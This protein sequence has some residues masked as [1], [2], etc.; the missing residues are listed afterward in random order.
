MTDFAAAL[1]LSGVEAA[2]MQRTITPEY[3]CQ[4]CD[5]SRSLMVRR[6]SPT[7]SSS[8][9]T[10]PNALTE[11][12][13]VGSKNISKMVGPCS[14]TSGSARQLLFIQF[15]YHEGSGFRFDCQSSRRRPT[16]SGREYFITAEVV[17]GTAVS[18][19]GNGKSPNCW[20]RRHDCGRH[21]WARP[22]H[23]QFVVP[24]TK[25]AWRDHR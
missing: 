17:D 16:I 25:P 3:I 4:G 13:Q 18:P 8:A 24:L 9:S 15:S 22:W 10:L 6:S 20:Q 2:R 5:W 21:L 14:Q 12:G 19:R 23:W 1:P 7:W 11:N